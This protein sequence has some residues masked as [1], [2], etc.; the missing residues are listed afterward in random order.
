MACCR[1]GR[2][3]LGLIADAGSPLSS[4]YS[5]SV[6]LIA[7]YLLWAGVGPAVGQLEQ[8]GA[9]LEASLSLVGMSLGVLAHLVC[10]YHSRRLVSLIETVNARRQQ[11]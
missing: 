2:C 6:G 10:A 3:S 1:R 11:K 5:I 8:K 7:A 9:T 4:S